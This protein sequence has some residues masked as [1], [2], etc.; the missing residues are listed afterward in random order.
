MT[1]ELVV[2]VADG[3][4]LQRRMGDVE[5]TGQAALQVVEN[6]ADVAAA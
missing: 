2:E 1:A 3:L 6:A 5:V 4:E